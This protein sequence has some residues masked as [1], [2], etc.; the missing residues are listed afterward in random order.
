MAEGKSYGTLLSELLMREANFIKSKAK[1][2]N[3]KNRALALGLQE[4]A[5]DCD[6]LIREADEA[7]ELVNVTK[8]SVRMQ[9]AFGSHQEENQRELN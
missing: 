5:D 3:S 2:L 7:I 4:I 6:V 1:A 9:M 8:N